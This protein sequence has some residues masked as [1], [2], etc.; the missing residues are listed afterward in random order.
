MAYDTLPDGIEA[1]SQ[2]CKRFLVDLKEV[3]M[4]HEAAFGKTTIFNDRVS[5]VRSYPYGHESDTTRVPYIVYHHP[6]LRR[7]VVQVEV[8]SITLSLTPEGHY[9]E[10]TNDLA[11]IHDFRRQKTMRPNKMRPNTMRLNK[12]EEKRRLRTKVSIA[13]VQSIV[14]LGW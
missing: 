14:A 1:F 11:F 2:C 10:K 12:L 7:M 9:N 5:K 13:S 6:S 8:G 4:Q 3:L